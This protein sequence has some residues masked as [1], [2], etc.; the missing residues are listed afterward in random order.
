LSDRKSKADNK[1][2]GK[3]S[4]SEYRVSSFF[5][6]ST[7]VP[8]SRISIEHFAITSTKE[9]L[10]TLVYRADRNSI[11]VTSPSRQR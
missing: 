1:R 9:P 11:T 4:V 5:L 10:S 7:S 2:F 6:Y 3:M 8:A